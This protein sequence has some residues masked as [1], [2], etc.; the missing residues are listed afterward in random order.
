MQQ[1][2][3]DDRRLPAWFVSVCR[4]SEMG[5]LVLAHDWSSTP[6]GA[7]DTWSIGLRTAVSVCLSSRFPM[8]VVWGPDLVKIYNDGYRPMLGR[9]KHPGALGAPVAE[10]WPEIWDTIG[11]L[12]LDVMTTGVPTWHEHEPLMIERNGFTEECF[13]IWSYSPLFDD[14]GTIGGVLDVVTE[15]T[16]EVVAQRR[17]SSLTRLGATLLDAE[18]VTD[19]C[20]RAIAALS[21]GGDDVCSAEI[22]LVVGD[23]VARVASTRREDTRRDDRMLHSAEVLRAVAID[24]IPILVG[25]DAT[26]SMPASEYL[27]PVGG[28]HAGVQGVLVLELNEARPF[29]EEYAR[30]L[31]LI[32]TTIGNSL[33][34]SFRRAMQLGEYRHIS[35]TLQAAMLQ[36]A[37]DLP[38][39]AARYLP[40]VG[41][42]AVGG[43]WYD[44]IDLGHDQRAVV[45]GDC[46]GHGL[47]AATVMAQLR[48]AARAMLLEG[49]DPAAVLDGLDLF[50]ATLDGADCATVVCAVVD[51]STDVVTYSRAGHPP[52]LLVSGASA[53]WLDDAGGAPLAVDNGPR[54]NATRRLHADDVIVCYSD[55][56]VERR[57]ESLDVGLARLADAALRY[58]GSSVQHLA[59]ALLRELIPDGAAD[60]VVLVVKSLPAERG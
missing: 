10:V 52:P 42:L 33:E 27:L 40:A 15:T 20:V 50:A 25:G 59:D 21:T 30:F 24:R 38:T 46:V 36:P 17:L 51:R 47:Q 12:F 44:V 28:E 8:L 4:G 19:V 53:T 3:L 60:D 18:Q 1:D 13:F 34:S 55:G 41:N 11:P 14:D 48:S 32:A 35:D 2:L 37:S 49:R 56:L 7:P 9:D 16:D 39:V 23:E 58:T 22:H 6:L 29:D 26:G 43:D 31:R 5:E 57:G 54:V 45:V